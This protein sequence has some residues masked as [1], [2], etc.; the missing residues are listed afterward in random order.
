[1]ADYDLDRSFEIS[2]PEEARKLYSEWAKTYD[3]EF[4]EAWGYDAPRK[5]AEIYKAEMTP[6]D[7]PILDVGGGTGLVA[8]HLAGLVVDNFDIT[9][10][11][12]A[13]AEEKGIYRAQILGDLTKPLE[14]ADGAYGGIISSGAFTFGH[15][16]PE[17]FPELMRILR[18]GALFVAGT[19]GPVMDQAGFGSMLAELVARGQIEPVR[20][21][22]FVI[23]EGVDHPH[24]DDLGLV[25]VFRRL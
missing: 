20:F 17:C 22:E 18:P 25:M 15:V 23:Y 4:G 6:E 21:R 24:K 16:G 2:G 19:R 13:K 14:I 10:E 5:I 7:Q 8:E 1:M 11:M 9:P 12:I 3:S